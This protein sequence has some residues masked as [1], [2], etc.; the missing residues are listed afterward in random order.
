MATVCASLK[1]SV[2]KYRTAYSQTVTSN[3]LNR[4]QYNLIT[5]Y[6]RDL[7]EKDKKALSKEIAFAE[8]LLPRTQKFVFL[9]FLGLILFAL[10]I[11]AYPKTWIIVIL[12]II[13][14]FMIWMLILETRDLIKVPKFLSAK[15]SV[16]DYW[17]C[18]SQGIQN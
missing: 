1:V 16:I 7:T 15:R 8:S 6:E 4:T 5:E 17:N 13:S 2:F 18:V 12:S 14:F 9:K 3:F 11:Y 10:T